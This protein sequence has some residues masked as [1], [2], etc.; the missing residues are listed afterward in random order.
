M[1][2]IYSQS[3]TWHI[4]SDLTL[5]RLWTEVTTFHIERIKISQMVTRRSVNLWEIRSHRRTFWLRHWYSNHM[6]CF[7]VAERPLITWRPKEYTRRFAVFS[8]ANSA[9]LPELLA[10]Y[11]RCYPL[12]PGEGKRQMG[13]RGISHAHHLPFA[14]LPHLVLGKI[15]VW[16]YGAI[17]TILRTSSLVLLLYIG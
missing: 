16:N 4:T 8:A 1:W 11:I 2:H 12:Q 15:M 7:S 10:V 17:F 14:H 9:G 5:V 6:N 13:R 3:K